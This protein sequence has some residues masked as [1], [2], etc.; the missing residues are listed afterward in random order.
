MRP[1]KALVLTLCVSGCGLAAFD[2]TEKVPSQTIP[3]SSS[4]ADGP[5]AVLSTTMPLSSSDLPSG[6]GFVTSVT[7]K[8]AT[9]TVESPSNGTFDFV[10]SVVLSIV[11]P[12]NQVLTETQIASGQATSGSSTLALTPTGNVNLLPYA[13]AGAVVRATGMGKQPAETTTFDGQIVLT[14]HP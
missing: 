3:G 11:S 6:S 13:R 7:L 4:G 12:T 10:D 5:S 2:V 1:L 9:F 14:V 8:S